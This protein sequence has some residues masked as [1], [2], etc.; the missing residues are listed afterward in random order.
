MRHP[1]HRTCVERHR[2]RNVRRSA[3]SYR[4]RCLCL[5]ACRS[6]PCTHAAASPPPKLMR[7]QAPQYRLPSH[8]RRH[9]GGNLLVAV[10]CWKP[11][12]P[13]RCSSMEEAVRC[14]AVAWNPHRRREHRHRPRLSPRRLRPPSAPLRSDGLR[15]RRAHRRVPAAVTDCARELAC[16]VARLGLQAK[17]THVIRTRTRTASQSHQRVLCR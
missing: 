1:K 11:Q 17:M 12:E 10:V 4:L 15:S 5:V 9:D 3:D 2:A 16:S 7:P 14:D 13:W 8:H 6:R